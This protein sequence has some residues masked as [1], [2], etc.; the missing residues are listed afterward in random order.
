M[1]AVRDCEQRCLLKLIFRGFS[2][3]HS[4][5]PLSLLVNLHQEVKNQKASCACPE[6]KPIYLHNQPFFINLHQP[7]SFSNCHLPN[8]LHA[9]T[10]ISPLIINSFIN[11]HSSTFL[12]QPSFI[13]LHSSTLTHQ[14]HSSIFIHHSSTSSTFIRSFGL[15]RHFFGLL[16]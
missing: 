13:N 11:L 6:G 5:F 15:V 14:L 2:R 12:H 9:S 7:P 10:F 1:T 3:S 4:L 8:S 16:Q